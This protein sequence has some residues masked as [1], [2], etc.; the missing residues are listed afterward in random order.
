MENEAAR[1][2]PVV[3]VY[4]AAR[5]HGKGGRA[6][7]TGPAAAVLRVR[8]L[9]HEIEERVRVLVFRDAQF[10]AVDGLY[11]YQARD[12][13]AQSRDSVKSPGMQFFDHRRRSTRSGVRTATA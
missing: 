11:K 9:E 12:L 3:R 6:A 8:A 10:L 5:V 13:A 4:F 7:R 1:A 2:V